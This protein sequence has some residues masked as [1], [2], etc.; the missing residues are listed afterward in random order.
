MVNQG[1]VQVV[2]L[3]KTCRLSSSC[4][5]LTHMTPPSSTHSFGPNRVL[6]SALYRDRPNCTQ[7]KVSHAKLPQKPTGTGQVPPLQKQPCTGQAPPLKSKLAL[8]KLLPLIQFITFRP[9]KKPICTGQANPQNLSV[10]SKHLGPKLWLL[11]TVSWFT[12]KPHRVK[13]GLTLNLLGLRDRKL[14]ASHC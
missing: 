5:S 7:R 1:K 10:A 8:A 12:L 13:H 3:H 2:D 9:P 14:I 6:Y 4:L 11:D